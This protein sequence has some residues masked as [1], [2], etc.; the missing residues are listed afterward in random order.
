[1]PKLFVLS[2]CYITGS[3]TTVFGMVS[4]PRR[5][6]GRR[7]SDVERQRPFLCVVIGYRR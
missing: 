7:P 3:E 4:I 5:E 1:M 6:Q 2:L